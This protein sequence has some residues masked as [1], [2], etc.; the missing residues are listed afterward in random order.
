MDLD[1][2]KNKTSHTYVLRESIQADKEMIF[3]DLF[4]LGIDPGAWIKY[5]GGN[6]WYLNE[7][8]EAA[9]SGICN[10]FVA[11]KL[12]D[13]FWPWV[14]PDIRQAVETFRNRCGSQGLKKLTDLEKEA[15]LHDTHAFDKR[16]AHFLKFG[17]MDQGPL[18]NMPAVL[19]KDLQTISR[20]EI[21]QRFMAQESKLKARN[22]KSYV[23]TIF[24]LQ[25]FFKGFMAK[26]MPHV[27]DQDKVEAFFLEEL[28]HI[29][30]ELFGLTSHL[31]D[32][33]L[34]YLIMFFDNEYAGT[35][36]LEDLERDFRFRHRFFNQI[37]KNS[38]S[39]RKARTLF[40]IT[41]EELKTLNK[42]RLAKIYRKFAREYHPDKGGSHDKFVEINNAYQ[43][44]LEKIK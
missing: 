33:L 20:D 18:S 12:E 29:N 19:F 10:D 9:V 42:K 35:I 7:D 39:T 2:L 16:R 21:E 38:V 41:R 44:L 14:R 8:M 32:Y 28:C 30:K 13:L 11:D 23:Y 17:N 31:D 22:L 6:A 3:H 5:P 1:L 24:D 36:L 4:D 27:L 34:K 26:K 25:H 40:N 37:P 43:A 15:I